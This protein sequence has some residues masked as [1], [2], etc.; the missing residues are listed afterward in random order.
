[1]LRTTQFLQTNSSLFFIGV[2]ACT[3]VFAVVNWIY[4]Q[5]GAT[6]RKLR[7][8]LSKTMFDCDK[9]EQYLVRLPQ[10]YRRQWRCYVNGNAASPSVVMEFAPV[11]KR[12]LLAPL[13]VLCC[14][15][16]LI[17][18]ALSF[19]DFS[20]TQLPLV[21]LFCVCSS[22]I[23]VINR[24]VANKNERKARRLFGQTVAV[25][26]RYAKKT[27]CSPDTGKVVAEINKLRNYPVTDETLAKASQIL[28]ESCPEQQ[29]SADDQR[30][31][32]LALN[33]LLMAYSK[34][35]A[36]KTA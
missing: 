23:F 32:N 21:F 13:F 5:Y 11:R 30:K 31:L 22:Q 16:C 17:Y 3:L 33:S 10:E 29:R 15:V 27:I 18:V 6:N 25:L 35:A 7:K 19:V 1:M 36:N 8:F 24:A 9:A 26:N 28:R 34:K 4:D 12:L 14:A 2:F 20:K